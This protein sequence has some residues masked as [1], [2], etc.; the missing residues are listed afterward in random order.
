MEVLDQQGNKVRVGVAYRFVIGMP[1]PDTTALVVTGINED[2]T[3]NTYD[4]QFKMRVDDIK[5]D[6][7][8]RPLKHTWDAHPGDKKAVIA[9][10]GEN[11][12]SLE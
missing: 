3:V 2:G 8:W 11:A 7:L 6:L 9:Y 12:I 5:P 1:G 10:A 4:P